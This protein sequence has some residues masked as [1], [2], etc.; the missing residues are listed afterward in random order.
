MTIRRLEV[1]I[2]ALTVRPYFLSY[3]MLRCNSHLLAS[4]EDDPTVSMECLPPILPRF[5]VPHLE[6]K[7]QNPIMDTLK[8]A[9]FTTSTHVKSRIVP[10]LVTPEEDTRTYQ[11]TAETI[12][13]DAI[14]HNI[15][16]QVG[17]F[18]FSC[19]LSC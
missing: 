14:T 5:F 2:A 6:D 16:D 7:P 4:L 9:T 12:W 13:V 8:V 10:E 3:R 1:V 18:L 17:F 19:Y 11:K 15:R